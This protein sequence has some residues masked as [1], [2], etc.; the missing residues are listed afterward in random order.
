MA[1]VYE[2]YNYH[3]SQKWPLGFFYNLKQLVPIVAI[4]GTQ[5]FDIPSL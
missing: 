4:F 1:A 2:S 3:V 5:Y